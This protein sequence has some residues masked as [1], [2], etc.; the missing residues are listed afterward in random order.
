M[1]WVLTAILAAWLLLGPWVFVVSGLLLLVPRWRWWCLDNWRLTGRQV[2]IAG[3]TVALSA[4]LITVVPD[5]WLRIPSGSGLLLSPAYVGRPASEVPLSAGVITQNP[6]LARNGFAGGS[7]DAW[8]TRTSPL[9]GPLGEQPQVETAWFGAEHCP[10]IGFDSLD[11]LVT[12]C[13][14]RSTSTL[15]VIDPESMRKRVSLDLANPDSA[16]TKQPGKTLCRRTPFFLDAQ[17]R[18][19]VATS[20]RSIRAIR[21]HDGAGDPDLSTDH[22]WDLQPYVPAGDCL[23]ALTA[24]WAGRIWWASLAG[25]VG[26]VEPSTGAVAVLDLGEE[27][28]NGLT[29]DETGIYVV[30]DR[31]LRKLVTGPD[32]VPTTS[33]RAEYDRGS[34]TKPGQLNRGSGSTPVVLDQALVAITDNADPAMRVV[35]FEA[36]TGREICSRAV[37]E[38]DASAS[39]SGL[40][41]MGSGVVVAN[42]YGQRGWRSTVLGRAGARGVARVDVIDGE[43]VERWT[44]DQVSPAVALRASRANGS[45]YAWTKRPTWTGVSAWYVTAIDGESGRATWSARVGRGAA[46]AAGGSSL[47]LG[48]DGSLWGTSVAGLVRVRDRQI[49]PDAFGASATR[50]LPR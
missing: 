21:T 48:P 10:E 50:R 13:A 47:T 4:A 43:C 27:I 11:R 17:D 19:V 36:A 3:A 46:F 37:F 6:H 15:H 18:A 35:F 22:E 2:R 32:G 28:I 41:S 9:G 42:T 26:V 49:K 34:Q 45:V 30:T 7:A 40:V 31:A 38:K 25:L 1:I 33:W 8:A 16:P 29:V 5:G 20:A 24:D 12:V 39:E 44:S 23:V 14:S